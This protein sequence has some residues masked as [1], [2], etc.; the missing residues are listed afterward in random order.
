MPRRRFFE[1]FVCLYLSDNTSQPVNLDI[2]QAIWPIFFQCD[3]IQKSIC[4]ERAKKPNK[5]GIMLWGLCEANTAYCS[6]FQI[7][8]EKLNQV[9]GYG[10]AHGVV[11]DLMAD[12]HD[13]NHHLYIENFYS[14]LKLPQDLEQRNTYAFG[15][16]AGPLEMTLEDSKQNSKEIF[17]KVNIGSLELGTWSHSIGKIKMMCMSYPPYMVLRIVK[18]KMAKDINRSVTI[19]EYNKHMNGVDLCDQFLPSYPFNCKT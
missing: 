13:R 7:N 15:H 14:T 12:F 1:I 10:L 5:S 9:Q 19:L 3:I 11:F 4:H 2:C 8:M 18:W 6:K 16:L 17:N